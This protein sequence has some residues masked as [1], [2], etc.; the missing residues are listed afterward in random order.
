[1]EPITV[2][3]L[4]ESETA[5]LKRENDS[6]RKSI[7]ELEK[8]IQERLDHQDV[9]DRGLTAHSIDLESRINGFQQLVESLRNIFN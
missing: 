6:L 9:V 8:R 5:Y 4:I 7:S 3:A 1:M 2:K